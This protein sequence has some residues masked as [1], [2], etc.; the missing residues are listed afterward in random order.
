MNRYSTR[1]HVSNHLKNIYGDVPGGFRC[2]C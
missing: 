2:A 1:R